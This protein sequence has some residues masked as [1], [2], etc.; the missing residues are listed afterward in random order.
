ML[1]L[2]SP[3]VGEQNMLNLASAQEL[4]SHL[5]LPRNEQAYSI[6][7]RLFPTEADG[8]GGVVGYFARSVKPLAKLG[9]HYCNKHNPATWSQDMLDLASPQVGE[10]N[11]LNLA[12]AQELLSHLRLPRNQQAYSSLLSI[13]KLSV[14]RTQAKPL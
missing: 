12:S 2:A 14:Q 3:Q 7:S 1:N 10:Q 13:C 4:L 8:A 9:E 11:M 6:F 5:R